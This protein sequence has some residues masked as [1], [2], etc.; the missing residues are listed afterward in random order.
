MELNNGARSV[1]NGHNGGP[2]F[3]HGWSGAQWREGQ[4]LE[5]CTACAQW[6]EG[7]TYACR[8]GKGDLTSVCRGQHAGSYIGD[9]ES[10]NRDN[11]GDRALGGRKDVL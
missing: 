1:T 3:L 9:S 6:C 4:R 7:D 11:H 8:P 2:I 10:E 5:H